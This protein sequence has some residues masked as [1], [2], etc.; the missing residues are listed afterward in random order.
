MSYAGDDPPDDGD[1]DAAYEE[2]AADQQAIQDSRSP[3]EVADLFRV[4]VTTIYR[5]LKSGTLRAFQIGKKWRI[6]SQ[7][8][9]EVLE[10]QRARQRARTSSSLNPCPVCGREA[11]CP[12]CG[13]P[14]D[15]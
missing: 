9:V 2:Y 10:E 8:I 6:P 7:E 15:P 3:E 1:D 4:D 12:W 11:D 5:W 14:I 13:R